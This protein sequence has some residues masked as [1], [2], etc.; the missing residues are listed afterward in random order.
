MK[1]VPH[2]QC[3][4]AS[5]TYGYLPSRRVSSSIGQYQIILV[6][7]RGQWCEQLA[8]SRYTAAPRPGV[9]PGTS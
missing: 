5:H 3:M 4:A 7:D 6:G 8:Q 1:S 9:E 2:G